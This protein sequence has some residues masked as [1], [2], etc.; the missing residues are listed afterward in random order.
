MAGFDWPTDKG[1]VHQG[2]ISHAVDVENAG[3]SFRMQ[4]NMKARP[5][6]QGT[7]F[8]GGKPTAQHRWPRGYEP[9]R[10]ASVAAVTQNMSVV[11]DPGAHA[12]A[13]SELAHPHLNTNSVEHSKRLMREPLARSNATLSDLATLSGGI[14]LR[15]TK[16]TDPSEYAHYSPANAAINVNRQPYL[17]EP[18]P[19]VRIA[20]ADSILMHEV[21][22]HV[23]FQHNLHDYAA[24]ARKTGFDSMRGRLEGNADKHMLESF[25]NDPRN[26]RKTKFDVGDMTYGQRGLGHA[27]GEGYHD[28]ALRPERMLQHGQEMR[29]ERHLRLTG[30]RSTPSMLNPGQFDRQTALF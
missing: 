19:R 8:Q 13:S 22:H 21:G 28:P 11:H 4:P 14:H 26:Q 30:E 3:T 1:S 18:D 5:G 7:L 9:T 17:N 12:D 29:N 15:V 27:A 20:Q 23:D 6:A 16:G 2:N 25:R 10:M 24:E